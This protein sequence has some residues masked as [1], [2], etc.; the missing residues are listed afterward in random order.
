MCL[1]LIL[2]IR[3]GIE[4]PFFVCVVVIVVVVGVAPVA[5]GPDIGKF[6][7]RIPY[8]RGAFGSE[9]MFR[10]VEK[11]GTAC[12]IDHENLYEAM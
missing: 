1:F 5:V 11:L 10:F 2:L 9:R 6:S 4:T 3:P 12:D 8:S 7:R